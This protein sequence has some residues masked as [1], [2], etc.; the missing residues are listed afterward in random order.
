MLD[1]ETGRTKVTDFGLAKSA[2]DIGLT[3]T[4]IVAGTPEYMAPEQATE[5]E[6]TAQSDIFSL[7][8]VLYASLTGESPFRGENTLSTL[9][10]ICA[11]EPERLATSNPDIPRWFDDLLHGMMAKE[12]S[13]RPSSATAVLET[14]ARQDSHK[15]LATAVESAA[16]HD[17]R[18][19]MQWLGA[20]GAAMVL[21]AAAVYYWPNGDTPTP[22]S[23]ERGTGFYCA[24]SHFDDLGAAI[25]GAADGGLIEIVG[26]G[27]YAAD[28]YVVQD[29]KL[30]IRAAE[31]FQPIF[32]SR[33]SNVGSSAPFLRSNADLSLQGLMV[34][35]QL[36]D[37]TNLTV[38]DAAR[39][40]AVAVN[41]GNLR[42]T[43]CRLLANAMTGCVGVERGS[44]S[45]EL[46]HLVSDQGP[47]V[48]WNAVEDATATL[49]SS[50]FDGHIALLSN[51]LPDRAQRQNIRIELSE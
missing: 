35:W 18:V 43:K 37:P 38:V 12:A 31:G 51:P 9:Q 15:H 10:R 49:N 36:P 20:A 14:L 21:A 46:S 17:R 41:G 5:N 32:V 34:H 45:I 50:V 39:L 29:K 47:C 40:C 8:V 48:A 6:V 2:S 16:G 1:A 30:T 28:G 27:P 33:D 3:T 24:G 23:D 19:T 42:L 44:L 25:A 26:D 4:G 22:E 11:H 7:G 13:R